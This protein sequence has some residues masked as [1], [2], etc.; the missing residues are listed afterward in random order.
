MDFNN[1]AGWGVDF[2]NGAG[3]GVDF[4]NGVGGEWTS[5]TAWVGGLQ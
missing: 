5:I 1:G 3:W 2:N 4:N